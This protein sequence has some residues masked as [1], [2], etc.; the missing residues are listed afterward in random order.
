MNEKAAILNGVCEGSISLESRGKKGF[1]YDP[2]FIPEGDDRT[3]AE[4]S[5]EEKNEVSHRGR[6]L[7]EVSRFL[8]QA[9]EV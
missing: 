9:E 7:D 2:I 1:G 4:M 5:P 3:F 6:V 8:T